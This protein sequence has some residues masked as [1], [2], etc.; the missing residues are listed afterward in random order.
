MQTATTDEI[1][2]QPRANQHHVL[3]VKEAIASASHLLGYSVQQDVTFTS[4]GWPA[5]TRAHLLITHE[6]RELVVQVTR[7]PPVPR[8]HNTSQEMF[9][10]HDVQAI[11]LCPD[12]SRSEGVEVYR[13]IVD[14]ETLEVTITYGNTALRPVDFLK[15]VFAKQP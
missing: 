2:R 13:Y 14:P 5:E 12:V 3:G 1:P 11:W 10:Q 6:D 8:E 15:Q 4:P 9:D 7:C